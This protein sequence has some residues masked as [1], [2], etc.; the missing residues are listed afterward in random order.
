MSDAKW[1]RVA[2]TISL[3]LRLSRPDLTASSVHL[4]SNSWSAVGKVK[5]S[6]KIGDTTLGELTGCVGTA[7]VA[8]FKAL[9]LVAAFAANLVTGLARFTLDFISVGATGRIEI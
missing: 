5:L 9:F 7:F 8:A 2:H 1:R 4:L 6:R 3:F